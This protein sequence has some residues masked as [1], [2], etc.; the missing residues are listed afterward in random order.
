MGSIKEKITDKEEEGRKYNR[1][2]EREREREREK[3]EED[4][5]WEIER[6]QGQEVTKEQICCVE[7]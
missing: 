5:K 1:Q 4:K 6:A 3:K 2:R 7:I